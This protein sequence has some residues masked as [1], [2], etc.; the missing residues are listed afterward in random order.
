M[1][2]D[3]SAELVPEDDRLVGAGEAVITG[4]RGHVRPLVT[5]V[6][7]M[8]VR[9]TDSAAQDLDADLPGP[10]IASVALEDLELT[11]R[12]DDRPHAWILSLPAA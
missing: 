7:R 8:Q 2:G 3:L 6:A 4:T 5:A 11:M 12:A 10:R 9:A 1:L